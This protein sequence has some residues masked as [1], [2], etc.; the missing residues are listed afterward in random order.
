MAQQEMDVVPPPGA[1]SREYVLMLVE[2]S[3]A[4]VRLAQE[5]FRDAGFRH[6]LLVARDGEQALR[7]LRREG[8]YLPLPQPD[9]ILLDLN[10]PRRDGR[11]VLREI[12]QDSRLLSIPVLILSTSKAE[13]DVRD[14]YA[15]HANAYL[16]KPV[17]LDEFEALASMIRDVWLGMIQLPPRQG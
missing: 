15:A 8:E 12:K 9:L 14:C 3:P 5:V 4:D 1:A 13:R 6:R 17:D 2:D 10:L 7:M 11:E 16:V